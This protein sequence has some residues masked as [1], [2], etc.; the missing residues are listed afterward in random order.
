MFTVPAVGQ[1]SSKPMIS[2]AVT[3]SGLIQCRCSCPPSIFE[4]QATPLWPVALE[5]VVLQDV[6]DEKSQKSDKNCLFSVCISEGGHP[7]RYAP[8]RY[9]LAHS[10]KRFYNISE[11]N[12]GTDQTKYFLESSTHSLVHTDSMA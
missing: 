11:T 2:L 3:V 9:F 12:K 7:Y 8:D 5:R 1:L 4:L 10:R 6:L